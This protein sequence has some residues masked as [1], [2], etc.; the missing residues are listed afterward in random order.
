MDLYPSDWVGRWAIEHPRKST[1][2]RQRLCGNQF[3]VFRE[4]SVT[5][6]IH[7]HQGR[8]NDCEASVIGAIL[9]QIDVKAKFVYHE[10]YDSLWPLYEARKLD[11]VMGLYVFSPREA[12]A[13]LRR[14]HTTSHRNVFGTHDK[15]IDRMIE[16][17]W[18]VAEPRNRYNIYRQIGERLISEAYL[19]PI[20]YSES[21]NLI[22][23]CIVGVP[24]EFVMDPFMTMKSLALKNDCRGVQR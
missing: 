17:V 24:K 9:E 1:D 23:K 21:T 11:A 18:G 13:Q 6:E 19:V 10:S 14:F 8:R 4:K 22:H 5:I 3:L 15:T 16:S 2:P 7:R 20:Y 12:F